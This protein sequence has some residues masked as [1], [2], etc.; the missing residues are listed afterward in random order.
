MGWVLVV[1]GVRQKMKLCAYWIA[2]AA[3]FKYKVELVIKRK[4][5]RQLGVV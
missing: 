1:C 2:T 4:R 3:K 5:R